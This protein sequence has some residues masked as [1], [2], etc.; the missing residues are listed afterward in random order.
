M[1]L[2]EPPTEDRGF[3]GK[4]PVN[5][6]QLLFFGAIQGGLAKKVILKDMR[7]LVEPVQLRRLL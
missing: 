1:F 2:L 4:S 7:K 3:Q 6:G 5:I